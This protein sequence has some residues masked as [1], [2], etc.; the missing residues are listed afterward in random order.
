MNQQQAYFNT[1]Q[2]DVAA[3]QHNIQLC[4][5]LQDPQHFMLAPHFARCIINSIMK[6]IQHNE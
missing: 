5:N 2:Y 4:I 1:L 3:I 6:I